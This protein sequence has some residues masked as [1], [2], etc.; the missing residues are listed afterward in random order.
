MID[1]LF[2]A[3]HSSDTYLMHF[4]Q[5]WVFLINSHSL[6]KQSSL[7]MSE[8]YGRINNVQRQVDIM[9]I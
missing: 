5:L 1:T 7:M 4:D 6:Q 8:S 9:S 3:E 2:M